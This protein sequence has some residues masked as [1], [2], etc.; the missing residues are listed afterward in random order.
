M[1]YT[2]WSPNFTAFETYQSEIDTQSGSAEG[3]R[4]RTVD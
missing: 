3:M 4:K 1:P 2:R